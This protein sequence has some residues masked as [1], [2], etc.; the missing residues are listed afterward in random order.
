MPG[1]RTCRGRAR[2]GRNVNDASIWSYTAGGGGGGRPDGVAGA[3]EAGGRAGETAAVTGTVWFGS[4]RHRTGKSRS[5]TV[6]TTIGASLC[7][8]RALSPFDN[9]LR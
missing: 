7:T 1:E 9:D 2:Y 3:A 8:R 4:S 6:A 5:P